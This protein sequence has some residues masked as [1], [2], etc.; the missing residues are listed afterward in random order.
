VDGALL[1]T[2]LPEQ[3]SPVVGVP[4][5]TPDA[6]H[7]PSSALTTLSAGAVMVGGVVSLT[8]N[9]VVVVVVLPWPLL[10]LEPS[11]ALRVTV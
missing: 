9:V 8:V 4:K 1:V 6:E 5:A 7:E 3:L 10:L 11:L 2:V